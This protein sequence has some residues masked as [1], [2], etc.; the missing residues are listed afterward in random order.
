MKRR[1]SVAVRWWLLRRRSKP[2]AVTIGPVRVEAR[3][4]VPLRLQTERRSST[5]SNCRGCDGVAAVTA[6]DEFP[7]VPPT[8]TER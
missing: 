1:R 4:D 7:E 5:A 6:M 2:L 3:Q 8:T